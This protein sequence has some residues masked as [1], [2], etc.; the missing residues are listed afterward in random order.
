MLFQ[1]SREQYQVALLPIA[2]GFISTL[3]V[4]LGLAMTVSSPPPLGWNPT[5][6]G[7]I[8]ALLDWQTMIPFIA[9]SLFLLAYASGHGRADTHRLA[10]TTT[11]FLTAVHLAVMVTYWGSWQ[12]GQPSQEAT[13]FVVLHPIMGI[14][15]LILVLCLDSVRQRPSASE[16]D[17]THD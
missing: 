10:R 13:L 4:R 14:L 5:T 15:S 17:D 8:P 9:L 7:W 6:L 11:V 1:L 3:V 16:Q 12:N 2:I